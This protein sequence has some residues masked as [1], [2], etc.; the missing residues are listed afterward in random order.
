MYRIAAYVKLG[1]LK[2]RRRGGGGTVIIVKMYSPSFSAQW[3]DGIQNH[4][5]N[6]KASLNK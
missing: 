1:I 4:I 2:Q 5:Y 3:Q 6:N